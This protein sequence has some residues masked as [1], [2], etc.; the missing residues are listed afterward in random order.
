M[1]SASPR[2]DPTQADHPSHLNPELRT[3]SS[4]HVNFPM[5]NQSFDHHSLHRY[6]QQ[7]Q[8]SHKTLD[9]TQQIVPKM[10]TLRMD[11]PYATGSRYTKAGGLAQSVDLSRRLLGRSFD[12]QNRQTVT[13]EKDINPYGDTM[14]SRNPSDYVNEARRLNTSTQLVYQKHRDSKYSS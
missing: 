4:H 14:K 3:L 6:D 10:F 8:A 1:D 2:M 13:G 12:A 11:N 5:T 9:A 7:Q